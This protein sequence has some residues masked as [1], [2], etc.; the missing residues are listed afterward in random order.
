MRYGNSSHD[1]LTCPGPLLLLLL[2]LRRVPVSEDSP[3]RGSMSVATLRA[4]VRRAD[5]LEGEASP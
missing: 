1:A 3:R 4:S 2:R 5:P